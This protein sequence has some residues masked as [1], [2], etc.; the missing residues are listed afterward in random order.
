MVASR[1]N[2]RHD[3]KRIMEVCVDRES[4]LLYWQ[5]SSNATNKCPSNKMGFDHIV[6]AT[7]GALMIILAIM[8]PQIAS[9]DI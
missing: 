1:I 6:N 3:D 5:H 9:P 4:I 2:V 7:L 8:L